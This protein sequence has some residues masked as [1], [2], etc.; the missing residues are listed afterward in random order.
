DSYQDYPARYALALEAVSLYH[1][2]SPYYFLYEGKSLYRLRRALQT[3]GAPDEIASLDRRIAKALSDNPV[4]RLDSRIYSQTIGPGNKAAILQGSIGPTVAALPEKQ[5]SLANAYLLEEL[6]RA[7]WQAGNGGGAL[8]TLETLNQRFP[9]YFRHYEAAT[10]Q[11]QISLAINHRI[12]AV[13]RTI[14]QDEKLPAP[15]REAVLT[16]VFDEFESRTP[17]AGIAAVDRNLP[18]ANPQL[19]SA[20]LIAKG[21]LLQNDRNYVQAIEVTQ[22][23]LEGVPDQTGLYVRG[24]QTLAFAFEAQQNTTAAYD[25]K[26]KYGGSYRPG[27][28]VSISAQE[29]QGIVEESE[30]LIRLYRDTARSIYSDIQDRSTQRYGIVGVELDFSTAKLPLKLGD[31][32]VLRDYCKPDSAARNLLYR[33]GQKDYFDSYN[34]FCAGHPD[35]LS[36]RTVEL[37]FEDAQIAADLLYLT[38]YANANTMNILFLF[39]KKVDLFPELYDRKA[40]YFHRLKVDLAV[41]RNKKRLAYERKKR[42]IISP[43]Q[44]AD[45]VSESDPFEARIFNELVYGYRHSAQEAR[46]FFD[47]SLI[48]GYAYTLVQKSVERERFY[49]SVLKKG[50]LSRGFLRTKKEAVLRDLKEAEYQLQY[51]LYVEPENVDAYLLLGWLYQYVDERRESQLLIEPGYEEQLFSALTGIRP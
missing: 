7:Q 34:S 17:T 35:F 11:G 23:G 22:K 50:N 19:R 27:S 12:P 36:G 8:A 21:R 20:L 4:A 33:L 16:S 18:E 14:I 24:W 45:W 38:S 49:D 15:L 31:R 51:I 42:E 37:P 29:F 9:D 41:E 10:L 26:L 13:F 46:D 28:G 47:H 43:D 32:E 25:A 3:L 5:Q 48:Y 6:A 40:I 39:V 30:A 44:I 2:D 1:S